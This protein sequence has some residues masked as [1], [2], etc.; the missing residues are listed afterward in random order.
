VAVKNAAEVTTKEGEP[1]R[2]QKEEQKGKR[3]RKDSSYWVLG[4]VEEVKERIRQVRSH[5]P[6]CSLVGKKKKK[7]VCRKKKSISW[8]LGWGGT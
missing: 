8:S 6:I 2:V 1:L 5:L 4:E 7:M 3:Q